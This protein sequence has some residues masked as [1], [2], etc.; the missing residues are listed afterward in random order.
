MPTDLSHEALEA[1]LRSH[2]HASGGEPPSL[3]DELVLRVA[4]R[5]HMER[6]AHQGMAVA[7]VLLAALGTGIVTTTWH[8]R[9]HGELRLASY[10]FPL[11]R[12][13]HTT[14]AP[15]PGCQAYAIVDAPFSTSTVPYVLAPYDLPVV[16]SAANSE[17]GCVTVAMTVAYTPTAGTPDPFRLD[18]STPITVNGYNAWVE[19]GQR[20]TD[21]YTVIDLGVEMP[22]GDG[23]YHDLVVGTESLSMNQV[24]TIV[25]EGLQSQ[26]ATTTTTSPATRTTLP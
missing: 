9:T 11:P 16:A 3:D 4:R 23:E 19:S 13:F 25:A 1:A 8:G 17:G 22:D 10:S 7:A 2:F 6:R 20:G 5:A 14:S 18:L 12:G 26:A 21:G 24:T 15:A